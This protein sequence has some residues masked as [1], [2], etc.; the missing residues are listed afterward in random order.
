MPPRPL[1]K[2]IRVVDEFGSPLVGVHVISDFGDKTIT[3]QNGI[4]TVDSYPSSAISF[5]H[6]GKVKKSLIAMDI[7]GDVV[8]EDDIEMLD[9]VVLIPKPKANK[10]AMWLL[11]VVLVGSYFVFKKKKPKKVNL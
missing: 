6:L 9:E 10:S 11:G 1:Q 4:A 8:L 7:Q 3:N 5:S 2:Q